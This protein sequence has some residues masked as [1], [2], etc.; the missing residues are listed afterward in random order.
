M[1]ARLTNEEIATAIATRPQWTYD[2]GRMAIVRTITFDD[3][4]AA[5]AFM[6]RVALAAERQGHHPDWR[7]VWNRVEIALS[8]HDA[9]GVTARDLDL[10]DAVDAAAR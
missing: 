7:N 5:F 1:T 3:F 10:A 4:E 8:T 6:V 9:G 2:S